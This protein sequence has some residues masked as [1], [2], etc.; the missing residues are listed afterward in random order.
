MAYAIYDI[1]H[2][3]VCLGVFDTYKEAGDYLGLSP[4]A[5]YYAIKR[6]S[7]MKGRYVARKLGEEED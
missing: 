4:D 2:N 7:V 6:K 3:Q 1:K 5:V